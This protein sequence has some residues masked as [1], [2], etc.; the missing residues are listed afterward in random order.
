MSDIFDA[1][2]ELPFKKNATPVQIVA[3]FVCMVFLVSVGWYASSTVK[4]YFDQAHK[5]IMVAITKVDSDQSSKTQAIS[6]IVTQHSTEIE[7]LRH[8]YWSNSDMNR[9]AEQLD[10]ANR[11]TVP[12]LIIPEVTLPPPGPH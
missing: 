12:A 10:H 11:A 3:L 5:E 2:K 6:T 4:D 9:W 8:Y 1:V 7:S